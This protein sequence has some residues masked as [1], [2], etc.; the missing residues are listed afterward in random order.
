MLTPTHINN[1]DD[2]KAL[3]VKWPDGLSVELSFRELR[4]NCNCAHCVHELT[5]EKLI[6][7]DQIPDDIRIESMDLVGAYALRI[8]WSDGHD[9]GLYTWE[10]LRQ[11]CAST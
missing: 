9:T 5:G 7:L 10:R 8:R 6:H 4:N 3:E 2:L 1:R 11:L